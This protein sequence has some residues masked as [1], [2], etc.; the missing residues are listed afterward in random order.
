MSSASRKDDHI[1]LAA[2]QQPGI[3]SDRRAFDDL[4]IR[5]HALA[6]ISPEKVDLRTA[7]G[8]WQFPAPF[9]INGMTG[10]TE[11][12]GQINRALA[13]AAALTGVPMA[14]GSVGVALDD[15]AA[16]DSFTVIRKEN[17][18]GIV[19]SNIGA[20]RSVDDAQRAVKLLNADGLQIHINAVQETVMPEGSRNFSTWLG[21]LEN[22]VNS[23]D[24]PVVIKEV[25]FG[26]SARTL[27]QL[28]E[29]GVSIADV[30]GT[31]GT[32][33]ARIEN[34]RRTGSEYSYLSAAAGFGTSTPECLLDASTLSG[35][36]QSEQMTLL[37]SGGVRHPLDVVR[38][39]ALGARAVGV[40]G[41]F[42]TIAMNDGAEALT[43]T[44]QSWIRQLAN[45]HALF[46]AATPEELR[47]TDV[48]IRGATREFAE[49]R[50]IDLPALSA[51]SARR[52]DRTTHTNISDQEQL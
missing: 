35:T 15:P 47:N 28:H 13:Q 1:R 43:E 37:A 50:G 25:G 24:V 51:R 40:A 10:G 3:T 19:L 17:P 30:S 9:F 46:G 16:T 22:I 41:T 20:G 4:A 44:L 11:T 36:E 21:L 42:L 52:N 39:L 32:D 34:D 45:I 49:L 26:L 14:S 7:V 23:L 2:A 6:A 27:V 29:I 12:A 38:A 18:D 48:L 5:H 31:G 8:P 33:F